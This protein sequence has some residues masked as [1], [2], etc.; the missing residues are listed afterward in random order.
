MIHCPEQILYDYCVQKP[1][2]FNKNSEVILWAHDQIFIIDFERILVILI[3]FK[4][5]LRIAIVPELDSTQE[6]SIICH[7]WYLQKYI[8]E[9]KRVFNNIRIFSRL[10]DNILD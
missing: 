2:K 10:L 7:M 8:T 4:E 1:G 3:I 9:Y 6:S 5:S